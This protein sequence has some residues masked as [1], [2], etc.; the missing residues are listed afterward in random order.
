[1]RAQL[2]LAHSICSARP[3]RLALLSAAVGLSVVLVTAI[4]CA[5]A[6]INAAFVDQI[7]TQVGTAEI[8]VQPMSGE[9]MPMGVLKAVRSWDG[10]EHALPRLNRTLS[11][12]AKVPT[13]IDNESDSSVN[14]YAA[15]ETSYSTNCFVR[16]TDPDLE[17]GSRRVQLLLGR[18]A[19]GAGEIVIDA[20]VAQR[21]SFAYTDAGARG[22]SVGLMSDPIGYMSLEAPDASSVADTAEH[23][24]RL[25]AGIGVRV[26]DTLLVPR[27]FGRMQT[28]EVVGIAEPPPLGGKPIGYTTLETLDAMG[29]KQ[30]RISDIEIHLKEG[31]DPTEFVQ[32]HASALGEKYLVQTT[33]RITSGVQKNL[34]ATQLGFVLISVISLISAAFI[35]TTGLTTGVAEQQR[36]LAVLRCIGAARHQLAGAQLLVGLIVAVLGSAIGVPVGIGLAWILALVFEQQMPSG[37]VIPGMNVVVTVLGS[38]LAGLVGAMW[39]A[40]RAASLSPLEALAVR[41]KPYRAV[42]IAKVGLC[43]LVGI[44]V[45]GVLVIWFS[46]RSFFFWAYAGVGLPLMFVGYFLISVPVVI[47]I[48]VVVGPIVSRAF[49]LPGS[50]L[51]R[52]VRATPYRHGF[53]SGAL[54]TG[55]A[56][57]IGIWTN[58]SAAMNDWLGKI[59]FPDAF[60]YGLPLDEEAARILNDLDF[61]DATSMV[62]MHPVGTDAFGVD[63]L[64]EYKTNFIAFEPDSFFDMVKLEF[65]QGDEQSARER[66]TQGGAV[67]VAREFLVARGLGIGDTFVCQ[68]E[69]GDDHSFEIVGVVTSPG[70]ELV[71]NYFDLSNNLVHQ[72]IHSVFGSQEDLIEHF[73]V[74]TAQLIQVDLDDSYDDLESVE[75]M[76]RA[77]L[78]AGVLNVGSGKQIRRQIETVFSSTMAVLSTVAIGA[79]LVACFGVA[80]LIVA[81]VSA[82]KYELGVLRAI[83]ATRGQLVRLVCGQALIIAIGACVLGTLLGL[84]AAWGGREMN[85]QVVGID[86]SS[87]L[88]IGA[89]G[90]SWAVAIVLSLIA[91]GPSALRLNRASIRWLMAR[92]GG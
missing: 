68:D 53:T 78:G 4:A 74:R 32:L 84:Q 29:R 36:M 23:A 39:P 83:G 55:L 75:E 11:L 37:L 46:D 15:V 92:G 24:D 45:M 86:L 85:R 47:V 76:R 1:M 12:V 82:R 9:S 26:G 87:A 56:L 28:L 43:G 27:L 44:A 48:S 16:G 21:L 17:I 89:I 90:L 20:R 63:G 79:M 30:G 50:L 91:S 52:T 10:V 19:T 64:S 49:I 22:G 25:N 73:G 35:I 7:Q 2:R 6:S 13:L 66:L 77:L 3:S 40:W 80:N 42:S 18:N 61:V 34:A 59:R 72:A 14:R 60:A 33:E 81:E 57:M 88:P 38:V 5:M 8:R 65:V 71:N 67:L 51:T 58:G 70:L 62:T 41:A 54:M 69:L 31:V